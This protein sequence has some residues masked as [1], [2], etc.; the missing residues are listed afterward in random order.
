VLA[1]SFVFLTLTASPA[2]AGKWTGV[3]ETIDG[4]LHVKNPAEGMES[5]KTIEL[6]ELWRIG[7]D[8]DAEDEFFG[9]ISVIQ[10]DTEGNVYLLD[11]QLAQVNI[12][13]PN[14][15]FIRVIG[16]EGE[17]PGEFRQPSGLFFT[18]DGNVA[19]MQTMP[20]KIVLLSPEGEPLGEH[21]VPKAE[22]GRFFIL[23]N[24]RSFGK[25]VVFQGASIAFNEQ[26]WQQERYLTSIDGEGNQVARYHA[27]TRTI[28]FANPV[29]NDMEW[30]TF[31]RRWAVG[32]DGRVYAATD[33]SDY[34]ISIWKADGALD[35]VIERDYTHRKRDA[36]EMDL[37]SRLMGLF[38]RQIPNCELK[39]T[40]WTKDVE[41]FY[42]REDGSM[43]VLTSTGQRDGPDGSMG[44]FDIFDAEGRFVREVTLMGDGNP[45]LD[46]Y[47]FV[48]DRLY[49]VTDLVQAAISLQAGGE[50]FE[51]GDE[52]PEPM[53][54][55]CYT[56]QGDYLTSSN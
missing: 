34:S 15:E 8:T 44:V 36:E 40:E 19:V 32:Y 29:M 7:G 1:L 14:G 31:D 23:V 26:R 55:I 5:K 18:E 25:N 50:S 43:W 39:I 53:A 49:V 47:Y 21:P 9:V 45:E 56:I 46:G 54:V 22:E 51:I 16:R 11:T 48:K 13:S 52:E 3:Q 33:Y 6:E 27:D 42:L 20:G 24:G 10:S 12:F 30:D 17:G 38:A 41:T 35:R 28:D 4:V 2:D 37:M